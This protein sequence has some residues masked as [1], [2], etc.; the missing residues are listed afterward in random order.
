MDAQSNSDPSTPQWFSRNGELWLTW[1]VGLTALSLSVMAV[2]GFNPAAAVRLVAT[3]GPL[4]VIL[5]ILVIHGGL[6]VLL[7]SLLYLVRFGKNRPL[8]RSMNAAIVGVVVALFA[9]PA[10]VAYVAIG[11][12]AAALVAHTLIARNRWSPE[13]KTVSVISWILGVLFGAALLAAAYTTSWL[14][15]ELVVWTSESPHGEKESTVGH[16]LGETDT[17]LTLI[18]TSNTPLIIPTKAIVQ[19]SPCVPP[20]SL[21]SYGRSVFARAIGTR[22]ELCPEISNR[23]AASREIP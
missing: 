15:A 5:S 16:V 9:V 3:V 12:A 8:K 21:W 10:P 13:A 1:A 23:V 7:G 6:L 22:V 18:E 20:K 11:V 14:P 2:A 17:W 19:R 4:Q